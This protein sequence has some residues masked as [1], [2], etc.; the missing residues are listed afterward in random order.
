VRKQDTWCPN[1][2][3]QYFKSFSDETF[4]DE[5]FSDDGDGQDNNT[6]NERDEDEDMLSRLTTEQAT[7]PGQLY[8][9]IVEAIT[10][11]FKLSMFIRKSTRG[12][13]F[14][15]SSAEKKY[16][17]QPDILHV[18]DRFPFVSHNPGLMDRLGKANAQRRQWLS[19]KKR[20][21]EKLGTTRSP[22]DRTDGLQ[23]FHSTIGSAIQNTEAVPRATARSG[24]VRSTATDLSSTEAST[25]YGRSLSRQD[26]EDRSE[27]GYS[28]TS[29]N[30][31]GL[32]ET[33]DDT[34]YVPQPPPGSQ[35]ENPFECPYCYTILTISNITVWM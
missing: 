31:S 24:G 4:S 22:E 5:A 25:F 1:D 2:N 26:V 3:Q 20:H 15:K 7:E 27:A 35:D 23:D 13:K 21:R 28:E 32:S 17:T 9:F 12:N 29:Y 33:E 8:I 14:A 34:T 18:R 16:E 10:S 11:L 19:Y 6:P 30:T